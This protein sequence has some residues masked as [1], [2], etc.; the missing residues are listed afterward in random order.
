MAVT[1]EHVSA[2][3][4]PNLSCAPKEFLVYG[5]EA[6][7]ITSGNYPEHVSNVYFHLYVRIERGYL[8][9]F[10]ADS[11]FTIPPEATIQHHLIIPI[12][13]TLKYPFILHVS[14]ATTFTT[15][16]L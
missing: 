1:I 4:T 11:L 16:D 3:M 8:L 10:F 9:P 14:Q 15:W 6:S 13:F 7:S 2:R 12:R 5:I